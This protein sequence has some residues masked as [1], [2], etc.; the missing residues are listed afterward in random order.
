MGE[1]IIVLLGIVIGILIWKA[2]E[3][4][5]K[6]SLEA[7]KMQERIVCLEKKLAPPS[8][9]IEVACR[10]IDVNLPGG[11]KSIWAGSVTLPGAEP[12]VRHGT[13]K[14]DTRIATLTA[15]WD[16]LQILGTILPVGKKIMFAID[17]EYWKD[18]SYPPE[19][20]ER[21]S[22]IEPILETLPEAKFQYG[23]DQKLTDICNELKK[24]IEDANS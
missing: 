15:L 21:L 5:L 10:S 16:T 9:N 18:I 12:I 4:F 14:K 19:I 11:I 1:I 23:A 13:C 7:K 6:G 22:E 20:L 3:S 17:Q 2:C 8:K 24:R